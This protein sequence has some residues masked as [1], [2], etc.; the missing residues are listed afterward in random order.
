MISKPPLF[1]SSR[2]R[3]CFMEPYWC[4][5]V[6]LPL[7]CD[8]YRKKGIRQRD[9]HQHLLPWWTPM[10]HCIAL[11]HLPMAEWAGWGHFHSV[12]IRSY[13]LRRSHSPRPDTQAT[14]TWLKIN[15]DPMT[16]SGVLILIKRIC[17]HTY[18]DTQSQCAIYIKESKYSWHRHLSYITSQFS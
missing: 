11:T 6:L 1:L 3:C 14:A 18:T 16:V 12:L 8:S 4:H 17:T 9:M 13:Q 10:S 2:S 5:L 15:L 7:S